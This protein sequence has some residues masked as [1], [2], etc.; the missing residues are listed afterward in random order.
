MLE[1]L[2]L[3][4]LTNPRIVQKL[5]RIVIYGFLLV[6]VLQCFLGAS[7]AEFVSSYPTEGGMYHWVA[8]IAPRKATGILAFFTGWCSVAGCKFTS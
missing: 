6:F 8:A 7:L 1:V 5:T 3:V 2:E 4:R